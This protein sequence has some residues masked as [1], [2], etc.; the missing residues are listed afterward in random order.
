MPA[1]RSE[2]CS[3]HLQHSLYV[4]HGLFPNA[5]VFNV[6][7]RL[8]RKLSASSVLHGPFHPWPLR[9]ACQPLCQQ[10]RDRASSPGLRLGFG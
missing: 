6:L 2:N 8:K 1:A 7:S 4:P 9:S 5:A 3:I 10:G